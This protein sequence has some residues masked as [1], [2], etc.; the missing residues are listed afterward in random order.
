MLICRF[1]CLFVCG[2]FL[3]LRY[4][5]QFLFDLHHFCR[6]DAHCPYKDLI[7]IVLTLSQGHVTHDV[8]TEKNA[9]FSTSCSLLI[10]SLSK[11]MLRVKKFL[12]CVWNSAR[13]F[14]FQFDLQRKSSPGVK[15]DPCQFYQ[16]FFICLCLEMAK[17]HIWSSNF[18][19]M[20]YAILSIGDK[21]F[22]DLDWRSRSQWRHNNPNFYTGLLSLIIKLEQQYWYQ[23]VGNFMLNRLVDSDLIRIQ[24]QECFL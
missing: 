2:Q 6:I 15:V 7:E 12:N 9:Q 1:V 24:R 14:I 4:R 21:N 23:N 18:T 17:L 8:I 13:Y 16:F 11:K 3:L 10:I 20:S 19:K 5:S 22:N